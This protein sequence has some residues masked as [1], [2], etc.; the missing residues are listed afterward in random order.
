MR[1]ASKGFRRQTGQHLRG[2]LKATIMQ[3][4]RETTYRMLAKRNGGQVPC[5]CCGRHVPPQHATL[6]HII[7]RSRG[8][9]D[10]MSN[11]SISHRFCNAKRGNAMPT[12]PEGASRE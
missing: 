12:N 11:L 10:E 4:R 7:P 3:R 9:T 8:G 5:F 1:Q 2:M 6:E